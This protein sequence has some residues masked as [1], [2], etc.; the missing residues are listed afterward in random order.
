MIRT[1]QIVDYGYECKFLLGVYTCD[2]SSV[3]N[4]VQVQTPIGPVPQL[5]KFVSQNI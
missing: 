2:M 4:S 5:P 1:K 3:S